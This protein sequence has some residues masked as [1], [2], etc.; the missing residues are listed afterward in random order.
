MVVDRN[1]KELQ[2]LEAYQRGDREEFH[3]LQEE[4][5]TEFRESCRTEDHCPCKVTT[6]PQHG[7]CKECVAIHRAHRDHLPACLR[8]MV[9]ERIANLSGLTENTINGYLRDQ[10]AKQ[11]K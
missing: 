9:N 4:F 1:P 6:C 10:H 2:A 11:P 8:D 7:N 3:R 5:L